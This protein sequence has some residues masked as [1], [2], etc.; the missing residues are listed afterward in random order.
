MFNLSMSGVPFTTVDLGGFTEQKRNAGDV[1]HRNENTIRRT[2]H[3]FLLFPVPRIHNAGSTAKFPWNYPKEISELYKHF[4]TL[5]YRLFPYFYSASVKAVHQN[6]PVVRP[7]LFDYR[8]AAAADVFDELMAGDSILIAPMLIEGRSDRRVY[9]PKGR[10][11]NYWNKEIYNGDREYII[12][13]PLFGKEG[14]PMF[15]KAGSMIPYCPDI[16]HIPEEDFNEITLEIYAEL[17]SPPIKYDLWEDGERCTFMTY[18]NG[19]ITINHQ[20]EVER[21][22]KIIFPL[23]KE[24]KTYTV[25]IPAKAKR[26][27]VAE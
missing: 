27:I 6:V 8:E 9:L 11:V 13:A 3:G 22:Y 20:A 19:K 10:W 24:S 23:V 25:K 2:I 1:M 5:R 14:L 26:E 15:V 4:L 17:N 16:L 21:I 7:I 18:E 12:D